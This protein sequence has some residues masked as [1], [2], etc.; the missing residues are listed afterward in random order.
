MLHTTPH[1]AK[2]FASGLQRAFGAS[3]LTLQKDTPPANRKPSEGPILQADRQ[4][5]W[6]ERWPAPAWPRPTGEHLI[7]HKFDH[8][9]RHINIGDA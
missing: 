1:P 7:P 5:F 8:F 9:R 2:G 4:V 3:L 6:E